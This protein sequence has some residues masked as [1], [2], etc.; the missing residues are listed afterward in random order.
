VVERPFADDTDAGE[1]KVGRDS[2][3]ATNVILMRA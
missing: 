2:E 1:Q 3:D